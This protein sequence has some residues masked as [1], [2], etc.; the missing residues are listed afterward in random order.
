MK[1][2][3]IFLISCFIALPVFAFESDKERIDHY[4][5]ILKTYHPDA[6]Q[7]M[8][9]RLEWSGL[10]QPELFDYIEQSLLNSYNKDLS[11][12]ESKTAAYMMKALWTSGQEKYRP[13]IDLIREKTT[14]PR[15]QR[16]AKYAQEK[17]G[18]FGGWHKQIAQV[19]APIAG[20]SAE[21]EMYM[22]ML[23]V[24]DIYVQRLAA[25]AIYHERQRDADL[26]ALAAEKLKASYMDFSLGGEAQDTMAW[27]CKAVGQTKDLKYSELLNEVS[28][29][30]P[31]R[32]IQ[33]YARKYSI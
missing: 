32:K 16:Y 8:L 25:R 4:I 2:I 14:H 21:V 17:L 26:I 27:L 3:F 15:L 23:S 28:L 5:K 1:K 9:N 24:D 31:H 11:G 29:N 30:S 20:K 6:K 33:K 7:K 22:R 12:D 13:T 19:E 10:T 18:I